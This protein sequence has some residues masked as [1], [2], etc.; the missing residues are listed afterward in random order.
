[1]PQTII[2]PSAGFTLLAVAQ[3][4]DSSTLLLSYTQA[5][6]AVNPATVTDALNPSNYA[7]VGPSLASI[8][9]VLAIS[10]TMFQLTLDSPLQN[11]FYTI[12][13]TNV[14]A[15]GANLGVPTHLTFQ[16]YA[17]VP[18]E[19][20]NQ[21]L[22]N[23]DNPLRRWL[24]PQYRYKTAWEAL[25][26]AINDGDIFVRSNAYSAFD[27]LFLSSAIRPYL[28]QRAADYGVQYPPQVGMS[29]NLF[30]KLAIKSTAKKLVHQALLEILEVFY[31]EDAVRAV[32][33][34][35]LNQP[36]NIRSG[37]SI[38][39]LFDDR[40]AVTVTFNTEDFS[41]IAVATAGEVAAVMTRAFR[42]AGLAAYASSKPNDPGYAVK[43]YSGALGLLGSVQV[44]GGMA[45][46]ALQFPTRIPLFTD[47]LPSPVPLWSAQRV[48]QDEFRFTWNRHYVPSTLIDI[49]IGDYVLLDFVNA[50][51][52]RGSYEVMDV[53]F[54]MDPVTGDPIGV[55]WFSITPSATFPL[56]LGSPAVPIVQ[57]SVD[58]LIFYRKVRQTVVQNINPSYIAQ[59]A[60]RGVDV[61][62][63]AT[64]QA[65]DRG[66]TDAAYPHL[67]ATVGGGIS[68]GVLPV[69]E[70]D[71]SG[72]VGPFIDHMRVGIASVPQNV[73]TDINGDYIFH[74]I[75]EG[76]HTVTP[77]PFTITI[78][79][80]PFVVGPG[81]HA[82]LVATANYSDGTT[83]DVTWSCTWSSSDDGIIDAT[84][85][86][87]EVIGVTEGSATITATMW[88]ATTP[89][90]RIIS[91]SGANLTGVDFGGVDI[92]DT[93]SGSCAGVDIEIG[94]IVRSP[95][96][97]IGTGLLVI[98][99]AVLGTPAY[100]L[101]EC[102]SSTPT[103]S[104]LN[105]T[106]ILGTDNVTLY[107][108]YV[109]PADHA[110]IYVTGVTVASQIIANDGDADYFV[111]IVPVTAPDD[112]AWTDNV[113]IGPQHTSE[114][115]VD[116]AGKMVIVNSPSGALNPS[117][118]SVVAVQ[119]N[120]TTSVTGGISSVRDA[121]A[122]TAYRA[123][124]TVTKAS[125][126]RTVRIRYDD[127]SS[128][129][130]YGNKVFYIWDMG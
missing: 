3:G 41:N 30:R 91:V 21:G 104:P 117:G 25:I 82:F 115:S 83:A 113:N 35:G 118:G 110:Q 47:P 106:H 96:L 99:P 129:Y 29:D 97:T 130:L 89:V 39:F 102:R 20:L 54:D 24:P 49:E 43:V 1:M 100:R 37:D 114:T 44:T 112:G 126:N 105:V 84:T 116:M 85:G 31:G 23:D 68:T 9:A 90:S 72:T 5:P 128:N 56:L 14:Q 108:A 53:H 92:S 28:F 55:M 124:F 77:V 111:A 109:N 40:E 121:V 27:Q 6:D 15:S 70:F 7:L 48:S 34:S 12:T 13:V 120:D 22:E 71:V 45:Q 63:P 46:N 18:L 94:V 67:A 64:T 87:G 60:S 57:T 122:S 33:M 2:I 38:S 52:L 59:Y 17:A 65:V 32:V 10:S 76:T 86:G 127:G 79:P 88:G 58:E 42:A 73:N 69:V 107:T 74:N 50:S 119:W 101:F 78:T 103:S 36:Y 19:P 62:F 11:G 80:D 98:D 66:A 125:V 4:T 8:T 61:I 123:V 75:P 16:A 26:A 95:I 51:T 81:E 93:A